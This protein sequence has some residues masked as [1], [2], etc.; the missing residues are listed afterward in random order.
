MKN[1]N[2]FVLGLVVSLSLCVKTKAQTFRY[3]NKPKNGP[4]MLVGGVSLLTASILENNAQ[5]DW[6]YSYS[7]KTNSFTKQY[8]KP[9]IL[10]N[11]PVNIIFGVGVT[12]TVTGLFSSLLVK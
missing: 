12:L 11:T 4:I 2:I 10:T 1:F 6:V 3:S 9:N 5:G 8:V 7:Q